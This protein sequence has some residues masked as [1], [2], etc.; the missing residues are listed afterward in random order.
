MKLLLAM[1]L[2]EQN[3]SLKSEL[4]GMSDRLEDFMHSK[5]LHLYKTNNANTEHSPVDNHSRLRSISAM[6]SVADTEV[7][8]KRRLKS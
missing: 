4:K 8:E 1:K 2:R 5:M 6:A 7:K 3:D